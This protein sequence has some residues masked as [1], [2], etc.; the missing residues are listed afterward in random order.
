MAVILPFHRP[1]RA[2]R[3]RSDVLR[4][5]WAIHQ[6]ARVRPGLSWGTV[7]AIAAISGATFGTAIAALITGRFPPGY[8]AKP[9][10]YTAPY[11]VGRRP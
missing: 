3:S 4:S 6:P 10:P 5:P 1:L 8:A 11:T 7:I 2:V 9:V